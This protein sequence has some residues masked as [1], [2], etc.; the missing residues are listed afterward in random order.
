AHHGNVLD[1]LDRRGARRAARRRMH[2][3][4]P[5]RGRRLAALEFRALRAPLRLH[6]SR[7]AVDHDVEERADAQAHDEDRDAQPERRGLEE[8]EELYTAWPI[9]KIGRYMATT[10]PPM[11]PPRTTMIIGSIN[12][13]SESTA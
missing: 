5:L 7:Q 11:R 8:R 3:V 2:E 10:M 12:D 1:R 13:D 6:H 9:L 4:E